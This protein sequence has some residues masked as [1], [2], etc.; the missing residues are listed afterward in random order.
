MLWPQA[1]QTAEREMAE[2]EEKREPANPVFCTRGKCYGRGIQPALLRLLEG[3]RTSP[4]SKKPPPCLQLNDAFSTRA[5]P[6]RDNLATM[7]Q[8]GLHP[9]L[10]RRSPAS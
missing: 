7:G 9:V 1:G 4:T 6:K 2:T 8:T 10:G 3:T 5:R